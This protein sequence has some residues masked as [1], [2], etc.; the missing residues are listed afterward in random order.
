MKQ[1]RVALFLCLFSLV[2]FSQNYQC[3]FGATIA[4]SGFSTSFDNRSLNCYNFRVT[5]TS[6]GFS[7]ISLQLES[8]PDV[9]GTPGSWSA[10]TGATVVT[11][12]INP[13]TS[14]N[15]ATIGIHSSAAWVRINL[16]TATGTGTLKYQ[17]F[18][19]SGVNAS[20]SNF[21]PTLAPVA[22]AGTCT[23]L[24]DALSQCFSQAAPN[25][26]FGPELIT[27]PLFV[28]VT[29]SNLPTGNNDIYTVA[30]GKRLCVGQ[31]TAFNSGAG[32]S[33]YFPELKVGS[34]YYQLA[35]VSASLASQS[36]SS[37]TVG[38]CFDA[39]DTLSLNLATTAG[40][41]VQFAAILF[42]N[43]VSLKSVRLLGLATGT[44]NTL[45]TVAVGKTAILLPSAESAI[46]FVPG[47]GTIAVISDGSSRNWSLYNV[48]FG[49]TPATANQIQGPTSVPA[50]TRN[51]PAF[52]ASLSSGDFIAV[53]IDTGNAAQ[54]AWINVIER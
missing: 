30:T 34:T 45:Y 43:T 24:S 28:R 21:S 14:T 9:S 2:A 49:S 5:Y 16:V 17:V 29:G 38:L 20:N 6:T 8:A 4:A 13:S 19:A 52:P 36:T 54:V 46:P 47:S 39:T 7:A 10:F 18:G 11:D 41:N 31:M 51:N 23:S 40:L 44:G 35:T 26:L 50:N 27:N 53:G 33:T 48:P 37:A 3:Q 1:L 42:D 12:G 25:N 32:S 15:T 22:T